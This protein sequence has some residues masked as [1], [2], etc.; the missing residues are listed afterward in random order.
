[1]KEKIRLVVFFGV[2]ITL[3]GCKTRQT[4]PAM[5]TD[6]VPPPETETKAEKSDNLEDKRLNYS[7]ITY[8]ANATVSNPAPNSFNVFVVNRKDSIIYINVSKFGIEGARLVLTPDSVK[9]VNHLSSNYYVGTFSVRELLGLDESIDFYMVQ[10][11][12]VGEELPEKA[13]SLIQASYGNFTTVDSVP[14]FQQA[15]FVIFKENIKLNLQVKSIK[16]NESG[17]T[18]I[19]IPEKYTP[20]R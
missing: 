6:T 17:P 19:R 10:S 14:F 18:S 15:D 12:L 2:L 4:I 1:M 5:L 7:W 16:L 20:M 3:I 9:F 8:R 13:K 11:L